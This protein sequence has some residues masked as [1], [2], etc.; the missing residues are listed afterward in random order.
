MVEESEQR[1][2]S[3]VAAVVAEEVGVG[4]DSAPQLADE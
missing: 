4:E 2:G 3:V 1:R